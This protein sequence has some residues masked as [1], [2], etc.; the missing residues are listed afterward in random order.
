MSEVAGRL[1]IPVES[2]T[3][4]FGERLKA[5]IEKEAANIVAKIGVEVDEKGLHDQLKLKVDAAAKGVAATIG[6]EIDA[7]EI[8]AKLEAIAKSAKGKAKV[9]VEVEGLEASV[10]KAKVE[11]EARARRSPLQ[12]AID[13]K[14]KLSGAL[15]RILFRNKAVAAA[16]PVEV[17]VKTKTKGKGKDGFELPEWLKPPGNARSTFMPTIFLG[18]A[19]LIQPAIATIVGSLGGLVAMAS[20]AAASLNLLGAAP[21]L[22]IGWASAMTVLHVATGRL[23]GK[24]DKVPEY[25]MPIRKEFEKL[26][27]QLDIFHKQVAGSFWG[28]FKQNIVSTGKSVMPVL[29]QGLSG[30]AREMGETAKQTTDWFRSPLFKGKATTVFYSLRTV[31]DGFGSALLGTAKGFLNLSVAAGPTLSKFGDVLRG[32][33]T[34]ASRIGSTADSQKRLGAMFDYAWQ[35]ASQL[36]DMTKNLAIGLKDM[37]VASRGSGDRL[38]QSLQDNIRAF[39]EWAG[40]TQGQERIKKWFENVEP[41]AKAAGRIIIDLGKAIARLSEDSTTAGLLEKIRTDLLPS[42]ETFLRNMG[43]TLGPQ[44]VTFVSNILQILTQMSAAG[45][46][47]A[48]ALSYINQVLVV[49]SAFLHANPELAK[50]LGFLLGAFLAFRSLTFFTGIIPILAKFFTV[51]TSGP[52]AFSGAAIAIGLF[53][54]HLGPFSSAIQ[55]ALFALSG[56]L[57]VMPKI[58]AFGQTSFF[59]SMKKEADGVGAAFLYGSDKAGGFRGKLLGL[60]AAVAEGSMSLGQAAGKGLRGAASGLLSVLGGPWAI[61]FALATTAVVSWMQAQD[62]ARAAGEAFAKTL[63]KTSGAMTQMSTDFTIDKIKGDLS[64]DDL[65]LLDKLGFSL[66]DAAVAALKGGDALAEFRKRVREAADS[67]GSGLGGESA[68]ARTALLALDSTLKNT[69]SDVQTGNKI[70][71]QTSDAQKLAA[72]ASGAL[73]QGVSIVS[74]EI[75]R[76]IPPTAELAD[77]LEGLIGIQAGG[78]ASSREFGESMN[79]LTEYMKH[80]K[81][82]TSD[83]TEVGRQNNAML[84]RAAA[85]SVKYAED[86]LKLG[87]SQG[88]VTKQVY[89]ARDSFIAAAV[90]MGYSKDQA[91]ALADQL[92]LTS[93][94][95][96]ALKNKVDS[97]KG[98]SIAVTVATAAAAAAVGRIQ[99][100]RDALKDKTITI[101]VRKQLINMT[102]MEANGINTNLLHGGIIRATGNGILQSFADGGLRLRSFLN[103]KLPREATIAGDGSNLVQ[104]AEQGTGGEAFIPLALSKRGRS[105]QILAQ[106]AE[107]FG[108]ALAPRAASAINASLLASRVATSTGAAAFPR[109]AVAAAPAGAGGI[110]FEEGAIQVNNP[111]PEPASKSIPDALRSVATFGLFG[112]ED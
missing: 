30:I 110:V 25:L 11:A 98:K 85:A 49:V 66:G 4:G 78:R 75:R 44:V 107:M 112:E 77:A 97:L 31:V 61:G 23:F 3:K 41:I 26:R 101:T 100:L 14:D 13:A 90:K 45:S 99:S 50:N 80:G 9:K 94:N 22:F 88:D 83:L 35:K 42:L 108:M 32:F 19:A 7:K 60:K 20:S 109:Q 2:D 21:A 68:H 102:H 103:G 8:R 86:Q 17:E 10:E 111:A 16:N 63:D 57:L 40:S 96:Q 104:W 87:K 89:Q 67:A 43:T 93:Q 18:I 73:A 34:Y 6:V 71:K 36:W 74:G 62:N 92:G 79:E 29:T 95:V 81:K 76:Q 38:L 91:N 82:G 59:G 53:T 39:R 52:A 24:L 58:R 48:I 65:D 72:G 15:A 54:G 5:A 12:V 28:E 55:T 69:N 56:F 46:P 105:M 106:V 51:A 84:D 70:W 47:L 33:G 1:E 64:P 27:P 37:L